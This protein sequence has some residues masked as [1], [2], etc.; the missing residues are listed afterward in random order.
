MKKNLVDRNDVRFFGSFS[1]VERRGFAE[2]RNDQSETV[3]LGLGVE[4]RRRGEEFRHVELSV[5]RRSRR[6][7]AERST[8][9]LRPRI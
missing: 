9:D 1:E 3:S 8:F 6:N 5:V 7:A 4:P 2:Q